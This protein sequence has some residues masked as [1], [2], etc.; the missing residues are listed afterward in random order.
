MKL[1]VFATLF[2]LSQEVL[3]TAILPNQLKS[4]L[5]LIKRE[6]VD[7]IALHDEYLI[8][9]EKRQ[10][11]I[12]RYVIGGAPQAAGGIVIEGIKIVAQTLVAHIT[13]KLAESIS[14]T[15]RYG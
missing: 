1:T 15:V 7:D 10:L 11:R 13:T 6:A 14:V 3:A 12:F 5:A 2:L 4:E 9:N 8:E